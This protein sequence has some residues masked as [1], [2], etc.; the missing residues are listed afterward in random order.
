MCRVYMSI[1]N[2]FSLWLLRSRQWLKTNG[3]KV[4]KCM[5][6]VKVVIEQYS[7]K[8][9]NFSGCFPCILSLNGFLFSVCLEVHN[10]SKSS[11]AAVLPKDP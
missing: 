7:G 3:F 1:F 8:K 5:K 6:C 9:E 2:I 4:Q 11:D 10:K